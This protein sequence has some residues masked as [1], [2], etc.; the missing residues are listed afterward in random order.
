MNLRIKSF[1]QDTGLIWKTPLA[2]A[3][4]WELAKWAGSSHPYLAPLTVILCIQITV[5]KS[6]QFAWQRILGT[7]LGVALTSSFVSFLGLTGWSIGLMILL[8]SVFVKLLKLDNIVMSQVTLS[9]LLVMYFQS[10]MPSYPFDRIRDTVIGAAVALL[11]HILLFPPDSVKKAKN[12]MSKFADHLTTYFFKTAQWVEA[13]CSSMESRDMEKEIQQLFQELHQATTEMDKA[14]QSLSY[15]L[16]ASEKRD[17]FKRQ[18]QQLQQLR[19]GFANLSDMIR[20]FT[21]WSESKHWMAED[22]KI[23]ADHLYT[24]ALHVKEWNSHLD[25]RTNSNLTFSAPVLNIKTPF[26]LEKYQY[27]LA[28]YNNANQII[29]D[30]QK[31]S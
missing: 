12:L 15:H 13:G 30:F 20:I 14:N 17:T 8:G 19:L 25:K 3:L 29:Q 7:I 28:L 10:Q 31:L 26:T 24:I 23:W 1:I 4:S 5:S 21:E 11:I 22:Q 9:I 2:A 16:F 6:I 27:P 18:T